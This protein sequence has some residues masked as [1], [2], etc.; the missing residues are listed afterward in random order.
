MKE[1]PYDFEVV[2]FNARGLND[3]SKR[4]D[5]FDFLRSHTADVICLQEVHVPPGK[6][7]IFKS[8]WGGRAYFAAFSSSAGGVGILIQ[9]K[10]ACKVIN[11]SKNEEGNAIFL[12]LDVNGFEVM[13]I[14]CTVPRTV[15]ILLS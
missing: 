5:V 11:M 13:I 8:Q 3:F 9:N 14:T 15:M 10:T 12:S 7:S 2:S 1:K 4:K 6:E